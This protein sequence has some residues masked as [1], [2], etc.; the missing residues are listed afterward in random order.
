[1]PARE[2]AAS[3]EATLAGLRAAAPTAE[4]VVVVD[5]PADA[6]VAAIAALP[7]DAR[8]RLVVGSRP[9]PAAAVQAG[10][11]AC[12]AD[13]LLF[14]TADGSDDP[15]TIPVLLAAIDQGA[16]LAVADRF[17]PGGG[18]RGGPPLKNALAVAAGAVLQWAGVLPLADATN[19]F[20]AARR[21]IW[22]SLQPLRSRGFAWGL[23]LRLRAAAAGCRIVATPTIWHDRTA[24]RSKF[25][26]RRL[27]EYARLAI[28]ALARRA[29][30]RMVP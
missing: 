4:I 24:G 14:C 27:P 2:E 22:Q 15:S 1:M 19:T 18:R 9:G 13:V 29:G 8:R 21:P 28:G 23:E 7:A 20:L 10:A 12:D 11:A 3:I 6:T 30:G 5:D 25:P 16:D 17:M 26:W